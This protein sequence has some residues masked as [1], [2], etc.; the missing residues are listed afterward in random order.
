MKSQIIL[1][2]M[3][4][5]LGIGAAR[6]DNLAYATSATVLRTDPST[7]SQVVAKVAANTELSVGHC[8]QGWCFAHIGSK[9]GYVSASM[10][11]FDDD[12]GTVVERTYVEPTYVYPDYYPG[13]FVYG[14]GFYWGGGY[15]HGWRGGPGP[16]RR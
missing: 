15:H 14:P 7:R 3:I 6:A 2:G 10:L 16:W 5:I 11:D 9:S 13:P 8:T 4:A 12:H 1:A